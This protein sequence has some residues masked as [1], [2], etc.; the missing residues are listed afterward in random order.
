MLYRVGVRWTFVSDGVVVPPRA[1]LPRLPNR[2]VFGFQIPYKSDWGPGI[3]AVDAIFR[4]DMV[5]L[6]NNLASRILTSLNG[7][8]CL[9]YTLITEYTEL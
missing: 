1:G 3:T 9:N 8:T 2:L 5:S 6:L 7:R 4:Q